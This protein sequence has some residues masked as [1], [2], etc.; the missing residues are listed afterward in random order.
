MHVI[1][2]AGGLNLD[3]ISFHFLLLCILLYFLGFLYFV[4]EKKA[5]AAV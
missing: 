2:T 4:L 3:F 5:T 1:E